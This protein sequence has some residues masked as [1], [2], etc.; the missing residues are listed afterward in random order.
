MWRHE[1]IKNWLKKTQKEVENLGMLPPQTG[2]PIVVPNTIEWSILKRQL[3]EAGADA[4]LE[5][6]KKDGT[7]FRV[8]EWTDDAT[9]ETDKPGYVVFIP[10]EVNKG[11]KIR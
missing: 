10:D 8:G 5:A 6:L 4:M 7:H 3:F 1:G 2:F 11:D 9:F